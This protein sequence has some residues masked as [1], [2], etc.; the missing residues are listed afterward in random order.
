MLSP[1]TILVVEDDRDIGEFLT[2]ALRMET[3][4]QVQWAAD[5]YQG[6]EIAKKETPDLLMLNYRLPGMN[7]IEFYDQLQAMDGFSR[8]PTIMMSA[9]L[10]MEDI[11]QRLL[12]PL[13]KPFELDRALQLVNRL[14]THRT[15]Q[16]HQD[17][18]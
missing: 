10:P 16:K 5:G 8:I 4:C 6:L 14:L 9:T 15:H 1:K 3:S 11:K 13:T 17:G 12:V 2:E 18:I 7:G